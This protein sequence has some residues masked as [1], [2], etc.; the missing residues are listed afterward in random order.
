MKVAVAAILHIGSK[1][2]N[3]DPGVATIIKVPGPTSNRSLDF[4]GGIG[5][6]SDRCVHPGAPGLCVQGFVCSHFSSPCLRARSFRLEV[7]PQCMPEIPATI[8]STLSCYPN[9]K[10][11]PE[12]RGR[13]HKHR[14]WGSL[15]GSWVVI[16]RVF[17]S[18]NMGYK[19]GYPTYTSTSNNP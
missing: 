11:I 7:Y 2:G 17:K 15:G 6:T 5:T 14:I 3:S 12:R 9:S 1:T 10:R 16:S 18:P 4:G 19:Y 8:P 13:Y